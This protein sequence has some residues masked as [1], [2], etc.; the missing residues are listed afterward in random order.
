MISWKNP[1]KNYFR[2]FPGGEV[3]L[4]YAYFVK[5]ESI[6]KDDSGNITEIHCTYDP[7]TKSGGASVR[8]VKG[9]IHWVSANHC[10][11]AE[12]RLFRPLV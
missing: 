1:P 10:R 6:I 8:K 2:L 12:I 11:K 7:E 9:T 3:R 4:K 5:C